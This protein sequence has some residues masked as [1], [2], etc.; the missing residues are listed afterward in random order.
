[1]SSAAIF[2][3]TENFDK[4]FINSKIYKNK[5]NN[6]EYT[7]LNYNNLNENENKDNMN[8]GAYRSVIVDPVSKD[9]LCFSPPKSISLNTFQSNFPNI[10]T[11]S[12]NIEISTIIEGTM[13]NLF[14]DFRISSWE[15]ATKGAV[16]G[17]Y[18]YYRNS[19]NED[20][21]QFTFREMFLNTLG[22]ES[23]HSLN[24]I[25]LFEDFDKNYCYSFVL[26]HPD[27]HIVLEIK[28][29]SLYLVSVFNI[30][31]DRKRVQYVSL[32]E[33]YSKSPFN[34]LNC[35]IQLPFI[36]NYDNWDD[37]FNSVNQNDY[38]YNIPPLGYMVTDTYSG[39]RTSITSTKYEKLKQL[40]GNN[41]NL[42]YQYF[43]LHRLN[44]IKE[45]LD[46]F[47][48]YKNQFYKFYQQSFNFITEVHNAYVSY[49]VKK[50][51]KQVTIPK[52]IFPHI[53]KL[54]YN[55]HIPSIAQGEKIIITKK[56][57]SDWFNALEPKE[58]LFFINQ[59][60]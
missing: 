11:G 45:F 59:E 44:Q 26:Q 14:Y 10:D 8:I 48:R 52:N 29:P 39:I 60:P 9:I 38:S 12:E 18:W 24:E 46:N 5:T 56:V 4:E 19:Y 41:P 30:L 33:M 31:Q 54:H 43:V 13:I 47:P 37:L 22:Y 28:H 42:M 57:V 40:R 20:K 6:A 58:K 16:G 35:P 49:Y 53:Y 7:I 23:N 2:V 25:Q 3:D 36:G 27:N 1:M 32:L 50:Q 21:K 51:G 15:I 55:V 34:T 17:N